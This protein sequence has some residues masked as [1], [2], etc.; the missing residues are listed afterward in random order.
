MCQTGYLFVSG[1][2]EEIPWVCTCLYMDSWRTGG[3]DLLRYLFTPL[4]SHQSQETK[5]LASPLKLF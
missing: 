2:F 5:H 4:S 3:T 1:A